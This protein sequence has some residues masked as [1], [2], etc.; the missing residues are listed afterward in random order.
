[1]VVAGIAPAKRRRE[2]TRDNGEREP[3]R[4]REE[5]EVRRLLEN[6]D[7]DIVGNRH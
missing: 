3:V 5:K 4:A 7:G 6:G 2:R 1:M